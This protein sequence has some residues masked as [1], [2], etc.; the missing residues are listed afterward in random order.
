M[1]TAPPIIFTWDGESMAPATTHMEKLC[2]QHF[3]VGETY[4]LVEEYDRSQRSHNHYFAEIHEGW[5]NLPE[6]LS[7]APWAQTAEHLRK[8]A[9][10]K[11]G[12]C[13]TK[14][15]VCSSKVEAERIAEFMRPIDV[16]S[17]VVFADSTV[18]HHTARSQSKK[19][20]GGEVFQES[21]TA[22]L[23]CIEDLIGLGRGEL[24]GAA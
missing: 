15:L 24:R 5:L 20:M 16:F 7:D 1:T 9:L 21:K 18:T 3:T 2:D 17:V 12:Y 8:Y 23:D 4:M 6:V 13:D 11:T 10:I 14:T 19:A 22:V